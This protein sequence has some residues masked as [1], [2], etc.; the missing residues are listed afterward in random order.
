MGKKKIRSESVPTKPDLENFKKNCIKIQKIKRHH[1]GIISSQ[2]GTGEA[3][4][5]KTKFHSESTP[6]QPGLKNFKKII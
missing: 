1:S 6:T 5:E 4:D 3:E 2:N